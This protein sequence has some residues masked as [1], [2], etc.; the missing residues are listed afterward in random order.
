MQN[1]K[2]KKGFTLVE[3]TVALT[4]TGLILA[5]AATLAY[6]LGSV[7]ETAGDISFKQAQLRSVT[8]RISE[9]IRHCKLICGTP[10]DD[11][12]IWRA[13]DSDDGKINPQELV[14]IEAGPQRDY[15]QLLEFSGEIIWNLTIEDL[16]DINTKDG[17][18]VSY[19]ERWTPLVTQCSNVQ[20]GFDEPALPP[21]KRRSANISFELSENDV[22]SCY[23]INAALRGWAGNLLDTSGN[24]VTD[25]D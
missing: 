8:V 10:G 22:V 16:Q 19:N 14:Y 5:A 1:P 21:T 11:L 3:L 15:L 18:I 4:V 6:A 13:D 20:F 12:V 24:L 17:L 25:D 7:N 23:Q 2:H 9:L